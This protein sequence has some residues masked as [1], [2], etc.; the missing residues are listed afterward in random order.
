MTTSEKRSAFLLS[1]KGMEVPLI[2]Y[3]AWWN[4]RNLDLTRDQFET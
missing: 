1:M 3:C 2:G 4:V